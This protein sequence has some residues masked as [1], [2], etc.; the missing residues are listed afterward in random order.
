MKRTNR[1]RRHNIPD[2]RKLP[3]E[4]IAACVGLD[5]GDARHDGALLPA[6]SQEVETFSVEQ[7][8]EALDQWATELRERFG[9]R[10]VAVCL[11]QSRGPLIYALLRFDFLVLCPINPK[12]LARYR[13]AREPSGAK[14]DSG[15]AAVILDVLVKHSDR[16]R[17]WKPDRADVRPIAQLCAARRDLIDRQVA[18]SNAWKSHLKH[19][20]PRPSRS[21][22][23]N[24]T[25]PSPA[26]FSKGG[27]R[28][29]VCNA[30]G[31]RPS[32]GSFTPTTPAAKAGCRHAWN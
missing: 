8:P 25:R 7:T 18:L 3:L 10:P 30:P 19:F 13:E 20:S 17:V 29:N 1:K 22:A 24:S 28:S 27:R 12:Q 9:G 4:T 26:T 11:E 21:S 5:S 2:S 32:A 14:D 6:G 15:D 16:V 31:H 23:E